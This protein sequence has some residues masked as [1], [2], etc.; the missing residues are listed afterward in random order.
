M[1]TGAYVAG[2]SKNDVQ[3]IFYLAMIVFVLAI[4]FFDLQ[5]SSYH[6]SNLF[7]IISFSV[8]F[9]LLLISVVVFK[10]PVAKALATALLG[11]IMFIMFYA[12][13]FLMFFASMDQNPNCYEYRVMISGL[14]GIVVDDPKLIAV[15]LPEMDGTPVFDDEEIQGRTCGAWRTEVITTEYGKLLALKSAS[16]TLN[17]VDLKFT[18]E[19]PYRI[20]IN[21]LQNDTM[22]GPVNPN[23]TNRSEI[24]TDFTGDDVHGSGQVYPSRT[25]YA[26]TT[27]IIVDSMLKGSQSDSY[28]IELNLVANPIGFYGNGH[29]RYTVH[30][31]QRVDDIYEDMR[32]VPVKAYVTGG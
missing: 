24:A 13:A 4:P 31:E 29:N 20:R 6:D 10:Y 12:G 26:Y 16:G 25:S 17:D 15:P 5:I 8:Y 21:N 18:K 32:I 1:G 14:N 7:N 2:I 9:G 23:I 22:P 3:N 19:Y 11:I 28:V 30:I 27:I